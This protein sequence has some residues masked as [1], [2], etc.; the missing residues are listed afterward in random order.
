MS[1]CIN[2][3]CPRPNPPENENSRFCQSCGSEL[4]LQNRYQAIRLLSDNNGFSKIYEVYER[5][6]P[7]ILKVLKENLNANST[8]IE[9]FQQ[10][11]GVLGQLN[12]PGIPKVDGYFQYQTRNGL[13]LHCIVWEKVGG[14]NLEEWQ[15]QQGN[16]LISQCQAI[17]Y[18]KQLAEILHRLHSQQYFHWNIKPSNII[19]RTYPDKGGDTAA[20]PPQTSRG[21][22]VNLALIDFGTAR[23]LTYIY[24][25][26]LGAKD[27]VV[28]VVSPGY[29]PPEQVNNQPV[30]QSDF[31]ALGRTF[32]YLLTGQHP[33]NFYDSHHDVLNWHRAAS[34]I[35]PLL[36][37]FID[38]LMARNPSD[39]PPDTLVILRRIEEIERKL[40]YS[41]NLFPLGIIAGL[42]LALWGKLSRC[43]LFS[44]LES[45]TNT[46]LRVAIVIIVLCTI[47]GV[48]A[49]VTPRVICYLGLASDVCPSQEPQKVGDV[50]YFPP[51]IGTDSQGR[52]AEF[53][54]AVLSRE[55][56]WQLGST[57][58][59][60]SGGE[61]IKVGDLKP[62][63]EQEGIQNRLHNPTDIISVGT[64][65]CEGSLQTEEIRAFERAKNIQ[66]LAKNVFSDLPSVKDYHLLNLGKFKNCANNSNPSLTSYQRSFIIVGVSKKTPGVILDEALYNRLKTKPF[67]DFKLEDYSL[68]AEDK[69]KLTN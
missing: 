5:G 29:T 17:A 59:I 25:A 27:E 7:K 10:E 43:R 12:Y 22:G 65:S 60:E 63:L 15:Q 4:L 13:S 2:P 46:G 24:L 42:L 20:L 44:W 35:S 38:W 69:F 34:D 11:A 26:R 28:P 6:T 1:L 41:P 21:E 36:I 40:C 56:E 66:L 67:G 8:A 54:I 30:P 49:L 51:E 18:L 14:S 19:L 33:L 47:P 32:V 52:T 64:A 16:R 31:F 37:D 48:L 61:I 9:R 3:S 58:Q 68:G 45:I 62:R 50:D 55:Y 53:E 57:Y 39:R 23:E